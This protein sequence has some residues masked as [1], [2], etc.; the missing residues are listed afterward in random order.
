MSLDA[1]PASLRVMKGRLETIETEWTLATEPK[2]RKE[3]NEEFKMMA[4][5]IKKTFRAAK[6]RARDCRVASRPDT[7]LLDRFR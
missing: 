6:A 5:E 2:R 1:P 3:L 7:S 4:D